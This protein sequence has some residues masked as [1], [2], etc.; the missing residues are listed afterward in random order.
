[1]D[2]VIMREAFEGAAVRIQSRI[3]ELRQLSERE[4]W[5]ERKV[6]SPA[7]NQAAERIGEWMRAAGMATF[8]DPF[9]NVVG[10]YPG[11]GLSAESRRIH[12]GSHYDTVINAGS[13]D[14]VLGILVGLGVVELHR[15]LGLQ[16]GH[17]LS[18]IAFCDEEGVRFQSTF[19]GSAFLSG[20]FDPNLLYLTDAEGKTLETWLRERGGSPEDLLTA[21]PWIRAKDVY[22]EVH[23]EQG[24]VLEAEGEAI[25]VFDGI[26]AQA[27]YRVSLRGEAGHAGTTP[28]SL[29]KDALS[30]AA[31][32]I[33]AVENLF[34]VDARV[35]ATVGKIE[36]LPG[37]SNVIPGEVVFSLDLRHPE[38]ERRDQLLETL[39][40]Q[41][42]AI[43]QERGLNLAV[44]CI[45]KV[46]AVPC[47]E[48]IVEILTEAV[49][50]S[51]GRGL[52]MFSGAGHDAMKVAGVCPV[53]MV[54]VRCLKG[55]S[56]H[57]EEFASAEDCA[58]ALRALFLAVRKIDEREDRWTA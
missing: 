5:L 41:L 9:S 45:H 35:M 18:V 16:P 28:R 43:A 11:G 58:A 50:E 20:Q 13:Y 25:G 46:D 19:L 27:R 51:G 48:A 34:E 47:D 2:G 4:E 24:P 40:S 17:P 26:A 30:G 1:M 22:L 57:P 38:T 14:G 37:A 23:I 36:V 29:R 49:A 15:E 7:A 44:N 8:E 42:E 3:E 53:G 39:K 10:L 6:F 31:A 33:L 21:D 52:R 55:L 32:M 56:H 54:P 12:L